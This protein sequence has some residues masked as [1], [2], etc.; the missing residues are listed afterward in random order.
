M[1]R[2]DTKDLTGTL[3]DRLVLG[4]WTKGGCVVVL[5]TYDIIDGMLSREELLRTFCM[6]CSSTAYIVACCQTIR[7]KSD[8][9]AEN[10]SK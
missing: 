5:S 3:C 7:R 6:H 1:L 9:Y 10:S 8:A 2:G 4:L